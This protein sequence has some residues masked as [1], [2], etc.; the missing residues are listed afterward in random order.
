MLGTAKRG[1][2]SMI[3]RVGG[4]VVGKAAGIHD[5]EIALGDT[6]HVGAEFGEHAFEFVVDDEKPRSSSTNCNSI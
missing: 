4:I 2:R 3:G 5:D 6:V 1:G